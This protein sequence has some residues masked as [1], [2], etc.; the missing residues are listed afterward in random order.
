ML[1]EEVQGIHEKIH[2]DYRPLLFS[3]LLRLEQFSFILDRKRELAVEI[4]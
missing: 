2:V 4:S 3:S 1:S